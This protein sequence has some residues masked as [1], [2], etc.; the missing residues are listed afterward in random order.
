VLGGIGMTE[1][2][3]FDQQGFRMVLYE[4]VANPPGPPAGASR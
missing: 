1:C 3:S 4:S 2:G